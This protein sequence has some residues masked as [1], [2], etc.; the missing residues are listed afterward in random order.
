MVV[1]DTPW[2][3]GYPC[4]VDLMTT[5]LDAAKEFYTGLFGWN[6]TDT[7]EEGGHYQMADVGG[8]PVAGIGPHPPGQEGLPAVWTTYLASADVDATCEK[9]SAAGGV[10]LAPPFD[11]MDVGRM[12][13]VQD[14]TG[15][16]FGVWQAKAHIGAEL[17]NES[18]S[19]VWNELMTRD[20][21]R[22][23]AFYGDVFGYAFSEIGDENFSYCTLDVDGRPVGGL[24]ALPDEVPKEVPAHWRVYFAVDDADKSLSRAAELGGAILRPAEDM[25]Y[26][27]WG[28]A[29]DGQ[30]AMFALM[31]PAPAPE[32]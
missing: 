24:G 6:L 25:P 26:G 21:E 1:R 2:P 15:A 29:A 7:G 13:I 16:I 18:G 10:L 22:A 5:D 3:A 32:G 17:A 9:A 31:K 4:W 27:R 8:K 19:F 23:K 20:Y 30:G 28:D 12:A 11:V 14:P